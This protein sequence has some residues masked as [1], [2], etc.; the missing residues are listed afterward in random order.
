MTE[1]P[2]MGHIRSSSRRTTVG[3]GFIVAAIVI[4]VDQLTKAWAVDALAHGRRIHLVWTL[5]FKLTYNSGM[6]FS[7]GTGLG[8]LIGAL[9]VIVVVGLVVSLRRVSDTMTLLAIGLIIGGALG[10]IIDRL[11]RGDA[12]FHGSVIDFIDLQWWPVFNVADMCVMIGAAMMV[13]GVSRSQRQGNSVSL[14]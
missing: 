7:K 4:G 2:L 1:G 13:F 3:V 10:N 8:P 14:S 5:Q 6:A 9:A 12:W 11:L